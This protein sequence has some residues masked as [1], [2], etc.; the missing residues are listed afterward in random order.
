[1]LALDSVY[2]RTFSNQQ[3][4]RIWDAASGQC[5][6][7]LVDDDNPIW[8]ALNL[9]LYSCNDI[10]CV[11]CSGYVSF[12]PNSKFILTSTQD[13]TIRLWDFHSSRCLKTYTGHT[14]RTYCIV[15]NFSVTNGKYIVSGS[16]DSKIYIWDVQTRNVVQ[17]LEG[18]KGTFK[19]PGTVPLCC[20]VT[21]FNSMWTDVV[22]A[23]AVSAA[24]DYLFS[25][26]TF[27]FNEIQI[28]APQAQYNRIIFDGKRSYHS[29]LD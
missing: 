5:L 11:T 27:G 26:K 22:L 12:S 20:I 24:F 18:H 8:Y 2:L 16:E 28:D 17:V 4:R 23:V 3:C 29:S 25:Q 13:S 9:P 6:K 10:Y 1:M 19:L 14:N 21:S 7:T 15:A